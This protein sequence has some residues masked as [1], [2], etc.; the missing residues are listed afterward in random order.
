M[1]RDLTAYSPNSV[2]D[3]MSEVEKVFDDV[4]RSPAINSKSA[5]S[6][7]IPAV[8]LR[9]ADDYY[10]IA[11]DVPGIPQNDIKIDVQ[12]SRL[13][14]SGERRQEERKE[15]RKFRR[16]ERVYGRFERTFTAARCERRQNSST[17]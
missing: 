10:L 16:V 4:W 17:L 3:F 8:D 12:N 5:V 7:F 15:E 2:W 9:E 11:L 6:A 13:M 1:P 14:I